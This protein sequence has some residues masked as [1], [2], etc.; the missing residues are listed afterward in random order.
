MTVCTNI[1]TYGEWV[2]TNKT[3]VITLY[4]TAE[5]DGRFVQKLL[6]NQP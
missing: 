6:I 4:N 1:L 5:A 2:C 3:R